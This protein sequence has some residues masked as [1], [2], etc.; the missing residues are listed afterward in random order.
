MLLPKREKPVGQET[1]LGL[2]IS[3]QIIHDHDGKIFVTSQLGEG[4]KFVIELPLKN[5][6]YSKNKI[7]PMIAF[8]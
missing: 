8:G 4:T 5:N 1:R 2:Y 6:L 3:E 7:E